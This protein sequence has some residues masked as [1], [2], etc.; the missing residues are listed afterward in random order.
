M[1]GQVATKTQ[2]HKDTPRLPHLPHH[3]VV[4]AGEIQMGGQEKN[5]LDG[6]FLILFKT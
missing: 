1:S 3:S 6:F 4:V 2:R 5:F